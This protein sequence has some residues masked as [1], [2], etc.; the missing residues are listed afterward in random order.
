[1][2]PSPLMEDSDLVSGW[3]L[4]MKKPTVEANEPHDPR[5][6]G[7]QVWFPG[8]AESAQRAVYEKEMTLR[9]VLYDPIAW[10]QM[11]ERMRMKILRA[12]ARQ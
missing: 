2:E 12:R 7:F 9:D 6:M 4:N 11:S 5:D 1:V 8:T 10:G 3:V